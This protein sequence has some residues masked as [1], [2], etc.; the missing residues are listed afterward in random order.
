MGICAAYAHKLKTGEGQKVDTSLF[1]SRHHPHLLA[2]R[3]RLCHRQPPGAMGSAHPLNAP[4]QAFETTDG[5]IN[6]GAANQTRPGNCWSPLSDR[7]DHLA[8]DPRFSHQRRAAWQTGIALELAAQLNG[9]HPNAPSGEWLAIFEN[10]GLPAGPVLDITQM[11][12][13]EQ[14]I[15]REMVTTVQ[16]DTAGRVQTIGVPVKFSETPGQVA[17][18]AP[19]LGR[20]TV[21]V[22]FQAGY[23]RDEVTNMLKEGAAIAAS[24]V[25]NI[26]G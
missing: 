8:N 16:H 14:T 21:E 11:H 2:I 6:V 20:D 12:A 22:L 4:Y 18:A 24:P 5:W 13:H 1:R 26:E 15:A 25:E 9:D 19:R 10:G 3:H 23:H 7:P 17:T